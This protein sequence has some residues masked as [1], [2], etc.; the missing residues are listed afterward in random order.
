M[1]L[2]AGNWESWS[3]A[4]S[5]VPPRSYASTTKHNALSE[6][7]QPH[8]DATLLQGSVNRSDESSNKEL[9]TGQDKFPGS[10]PH[11]PRHLR[12][13]PVDSRSLSPVIDSSIAAGIRST[14][15]PSST[16]AH[17]EANS[18]FS[19]AKHASARLLSDQEK[20]AQAFQAK[21]SLANA[22]QEQSWNATAFKTSEVVDAA[23]VDRA[24]ATTEARWKRQARSAEQAVDE[25]E[26]ELANV[27]Q[28][29]DWR[30]RATRA[31]KLVDNFLRENAS[32]GAEEAWAKA[33][34]AAERL[35]DKYAKIS[36]DAWTELDWETKAMEVEAVIDRFLADAKAAWAKK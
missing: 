24:N 36:A 8:P 12:A 35:V 3:V 1:S 18:D 11:F 27:R 32:V 13:S 21:G 14:I 25:S 30:K 19:H 2:L 22:A 28:E 23:E 17:V 9:L 10:S 7:A 20:A 4:D 33:S 16:Q 26:K 6:S 34:A 29:G 31:E 5:V 15:D